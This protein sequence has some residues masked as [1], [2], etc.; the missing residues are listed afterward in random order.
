MRRLRMEHLQSR[1]KLNG[2]VTTVCI[3]V[4]GWIKSASLPQRRMILC[5]W[6]C[7]GMVRVLYLKESFGFHAFRPERICPTDSHNLPCVRMVYKCAF[8]TTKQ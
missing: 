2:C 8:G 1:Y 5:C 3:I 4:C 6:L 7:A